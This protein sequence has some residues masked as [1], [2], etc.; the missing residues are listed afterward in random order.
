MR[1]ENK[2]SWKNG[3][4][5]RKKHEWRS[6]QRYLSEVYWSDKAKQWTNDWPLS[7]TTFKTRAIHQVYLTKNGRWFHM[8]AVITWLTSHAHVHAKW[9]DG[10]TAYS[11]NSVSIW[12]LS[13]IIV[14][15]C[16]FCR[17]L[18]TDSSTARGR[19]LVVLMNHSFIHSFIDNT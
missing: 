6:K 10:R 15:L 13:L 1:Y 4:R 7:M 18:I 11:S 2:G 5:R 3:S 16:I 17:V 12:S 9:M 8:S 14:H 19:L